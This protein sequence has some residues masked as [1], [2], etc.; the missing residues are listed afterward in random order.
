MLLVGANVPNNG[1]LMAKLTA[2]DVPPPGAGLVTVT[3]TVPAE[4]MAAAGTFTSNCVEPTLTLEITSAPKLTV[5]EPMMK[6][7]PIICRVKGAPPAAALFGD[8]VMI[9]G[10]VIAGVV[11]LDPLGTAVEALYPHP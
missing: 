11:G 7:V 10:V 9:V 8:I 6:F 3:A 2:F 4:A 5:V 1:E